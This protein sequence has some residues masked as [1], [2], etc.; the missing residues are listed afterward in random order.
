MREPTPD[1]RLQRRQ[2][3]TRTGTGLGAISVNGLLNPALYAGA[4]GN[5]VEERMAVRHFVP[6]ARRVVF[7]FMA[8][9]PSHLDLWDPKPE[10]QARNGSELPASIRQG[11][12]ITTMTR[13]QKQLLVAA[14]PMRFRSYGNS[15]QMMNEHLPR[16]GK[17][18]DELAIVRSIHSEP[19]NHDPAVNMIQT[20]AGRAGRP[21]IGS[22]VSWALGSENRN[23][24]D[25]VVLLSGS[26][27]Q[28]VI[29]RYYHSGFLPSR[30]QGVQFLSQ[31]E[32]VLFL[33]NPNG[34]NQAQ[35]DELIAGINALNRRRLE[36]VGDPEIEARI[37]SFEL[38]GRMQTSV[39]ELMDIRREPKH[40]HEQY[41]T[42]PGKVSYAN[43]CL[44]ARRLLERGV[45]FVQLYQRGW[46]M[47]SKIKTRMPEMCRTID[48]PTAALIE[49]LRRRGML[50]DTLIV[51]GGEFGRTTYCQ[52]ELVPEFGRDHHPRCFSMWLAGGGIRGG[53]ALGRTD[54]YG[55]NIVEDGVHIHDLQ[56][57]VLHCLGMDHTR[58]T[59]RF[60]GRDQRLTDIGGKVVHR[61]LS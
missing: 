38:A 34:I 59:Y 55:Y 6:R 24:P 44:L 60:Q 33:S 47:H 20:G 57:T 4:E 36:V 11:Q 32:P 2:F 18:A 27:G 40:I 30:H 10:L 52:G 49:D 45:R 61:I 31:G 29:S 51:W 22:W 23:L 8:G 21:C 56:A 12:R 37:D 3:L 43:N 28:P 16:L 42:E 13:G 35:R 26:K 9:G 41:G 7:L 14:S 54:D 1:H 39:P 25:F 15:G 48:R 53:T 46:D 58:L 17:M 50:E 5:G 19:I